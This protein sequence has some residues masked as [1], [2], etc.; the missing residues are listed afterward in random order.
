M[1]QTIVT[2]IFFYILGAILAPLCAPDN[3]TN[4]YYLAYGVLWPFWL[5]RAICRGVVNVWHD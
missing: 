1:H 3:K 5:V 4:S 2:I